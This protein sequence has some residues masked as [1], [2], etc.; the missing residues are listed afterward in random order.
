[1]SSASQG[2]SV[3]NTDKHQNNYL[4]QAKKPSKV[5]ASPHGSLVWSHLAPNSYCAAYT[6]LIWCFYNRDVKLSPLL[7]FTQAH[8]HIQTCT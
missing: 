8:P 5:S 7:A 3:N 6:D 4:L 2:M 1:M